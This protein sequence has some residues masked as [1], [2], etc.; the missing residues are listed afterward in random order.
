MSRLI[1]PFLNLGLILCLGV[2][3]V[4]CSGGEERQTKYLDRA[5]QYF[6]D[7]NYEKARVDLKNVL[8]I[9]ANNT[10]ARYMMAL[11]EEKEG[12]WRAVY[13]NLNAVVELDEN[14]LQAITKL[15]TILLASKQI[16]LATEKADRAMELAP[17]NANSLALMASV[18]AVR[19]NKDIA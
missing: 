11:V 14:H 18:E 3:L 9:N 19:E 17:A 2:V 7:G 4:A 6:D 13:G 10:D 5:Q 16:E 15:G 12:N 8:Q 1:K